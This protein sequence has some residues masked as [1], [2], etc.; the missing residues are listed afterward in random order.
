MPRLSKKAPSYRRQHRPNAVDDAFVELL[1][2]VSISVHT[3]PRLAMEIK[4]CPTPFWK[5]G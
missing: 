2:R 3:V 4:R 5:H 1:A